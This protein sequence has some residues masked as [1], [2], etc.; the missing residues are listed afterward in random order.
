LE[1]ITNFLQSL[2]SENLAG[3]DLA[4]LPEH[5]TPS[6]SENYQRDRLS[7][8]STKKAPPNSP[9]RS[10][11]ERAGLGLELTPLRTQDR[12]IVGQIRQ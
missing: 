4:S 3:F 1:Q 5:T 8:F 11:S 2:S 7:T 12:H 6:P 9:V 10:E